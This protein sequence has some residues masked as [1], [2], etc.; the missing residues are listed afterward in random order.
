[1]AVTIN[2]L[3]KQNMAI[4]ADGVVVVAEHDPQHILGALHNFIFMLDV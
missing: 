3:K 2:T 1:M 4:F